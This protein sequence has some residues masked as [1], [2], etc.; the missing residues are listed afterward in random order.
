MTSIRGR[1][2]SFLIAIVCNATVISC[3]AK[4]DQ[5]AKSTLTSPGTQSPATANAVSNKPT[6]TPVAKP[7]IP[8][9]PKNR[10]EGTRARG[11]EPSSITQTKAGVPRTVN[12]R[13]DSKIKSASSALLE[14]ADAATG[15]GALMKNETAALTAEL[16]EALVLALAECKLV[17]RGIDKKCSAY[18]TLREARGRTTAQKDLFG[19]NAALGSRLLGHSSP[20]VRLQAATMV[21]SILG[22]NPAGQLAIEKAARMEADPTV[23][24]AMLNVVGSRHLASPDMKKLF[25]DMADHADAGVRQEVIGWFLS[26]FSRGSD[27][28]FE[29]AV[30][31]LASDASDDLRTYACEK[32]YG[33]GNS[34]ALVH[35]K[36]YLLAPDTPEPLYQACFKGLLSTWTG[37][38]LPA[39][40]LKSGYEL[41]L[42]LLKATPRTK[43]RPPWGAL[44]AL[45]AARTKPIIKANETW[46][47]AVKGW[48]RVEDLAAALA[49]LAKDR[50]TKWMARAIATRTIAEIGG[51]RALIQGIRDAYEVIDLK[52][53]SD[54]HVRKAAERTLAMMPK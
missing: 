54:S 42:Q 24:R 37:Y 29:K 11:S 8:I 30:T 23:L 43:Q 49:N 38:P 4:N 40:P 1:Y 13:M 3:E 16:Y 26:S 27:A 19:A 46:A 47:T 50:N 10:T 5:T 32:L 48:Y 21:G 2:R 25:F 51:S 41:T 53:A 45:G 22:T 12:T 34:N 17:G 15:V 14:S 31:M 44:S 7:G 52:H 9:L 18:K 28:T 36:K 35:M 33:S 6:V 20:A 39:E